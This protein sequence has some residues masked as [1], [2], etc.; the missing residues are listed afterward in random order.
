MCCSRCPEIMGLNFHFRIKRRHKLTETARADIEDLCR[1]SKIGDVLLQV[2]RKVRREGNCFVPSLVF[3]LKEIN[4]SFSCCWIEN[5]SSSSKTVNILSSTCNFVQ[6]QYNQ[7]T[8]VMFWGVDQFFNQLHQPFIVVAVV[9][10]NVF[11]LLSFPFFAKIEE[12]VVGV[13]EAL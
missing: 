13:V 3:A 9:W 6:Q 8:H 11:R 10:M 7:S 12:L 4:C 2:E 5:N 1:W